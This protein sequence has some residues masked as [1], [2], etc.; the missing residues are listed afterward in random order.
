MYTLRGRCEDIHGAVQRPIV[1]LL[2]ACSL[3]SHRRQSSLR[4]LLRGLAG[5][6]ELGSLLFPPFLQ[7]PTLFHEFGH[8]MHLLLTDTRFVQISGTRVA[9]RRM[10]RPHKQGDAVELPSTLFE[11]FA[12][13]PAILAAINEASMKRSSNVVAG[14]DAVVE[15]SPILHLVRE[16]SSRSS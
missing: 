12:D 15:I 1:A 10:K 2:G 5:R 8:A 9:V 3:G 6:R 14:T 4:K 13:S 16:D 11:R 7:I